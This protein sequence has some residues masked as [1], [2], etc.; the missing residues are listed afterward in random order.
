MPPIGTAIDGVLFLTITPQQS[1]LRSEC[2]VAQDRCRACVKREN[3]GEKFSRDF[4]V[5]FLREAGRCTG[6]GEILLEMHLLL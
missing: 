2:E 6:K 1:L 4:S 3:A 5:S